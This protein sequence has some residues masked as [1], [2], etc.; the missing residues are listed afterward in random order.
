MK[1]S[2][3]TT[4][5]INLPYTVAVKHQLHF[6]YKSQFVPVQLNEVIARP[7]KN[8]NAKAAFQQ[9]VSNINKDINFNTLKCIEILGKKFR[10][11]TFFLL[12]ISDSH[13]I[14]FATVNN[15]FSCDNGN[16]YVLTIT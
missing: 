10:S 4:C 14:S 8:I 9:L 6:C 12:D 3:S 5:H 1:F 15:I 13:N 11:D 2:E 16:I 7:V